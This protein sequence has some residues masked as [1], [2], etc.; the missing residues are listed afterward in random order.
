MHKYVHTCLYAHL[1]TR[2][3]RAITAIKAKLAKLL[4]VSV[5]R[6]E[7]RLKDSTSAAANRRLLLLPLVEMEEGVYI[8]MAIS[9]HAFTPVRSHGQLS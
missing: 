1:C 2:F 4:G 6:I 3:E 7:I 8:S 5:E 9:T